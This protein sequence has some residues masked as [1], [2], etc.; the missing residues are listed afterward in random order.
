MSKKER[1]LVTSALPYAN[2]PL[3]VGHAIG[4][5][6]PADVYVRYRKLRGDDVIFICGTDEYGTPISV[7]AEEEGVGG[8]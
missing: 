8:E 6:V 2:G 3:H 7:R 4:A 1:Y 5:Y